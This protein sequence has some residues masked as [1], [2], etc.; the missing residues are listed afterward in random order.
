MSYGGHY[1]GG[2]NGR[3]IH[4]NGRDRDR[5]SSRLDRN[6]RNERNDRNDRNDRSYNSRYGNSQ[7]RYGQ[8]SSSYGEQA[9]GSG[10]RRQE[11]R[12]FYGY[13]NNNN[14]NSPNTNNSYNRADTSDR[15][16]GTSG[17]AVNAR[18]RDRNSQ[19]D[20][21]QG[22]K[23]RPHLGKPKG[24]G[25]AQNTDPIS[26]RVS[27]SSSRND[28]RAEESTKDLIDDRRLSNRKQDWDASMYQNPRNPQNRP[29]HTSRDQY[30][31][32]SKYHVPVK[33]HS[34]IDFEAGSGS[35]KR[36]SSDTEG[37]ESR[38]ENRD[39]KG[40]QSN[41]TNYTKP[42]NKYTKAPYINSS[43]RPSSTSSKQS[44]TENSPV[45]PALGQT[46]SKISPQQSSQ[47]SS[48]MSSQPQT[49]SARPETLHKP[50]EPPVT[51]SNTEGKQK[52]EPSPQYNVESDRK[53]K[54]L[55]SMF[56]DDE[57]NTPHSDPIKKDSSEKTT[58]TK[59]GKSGDTHMED[60]SVSLSSNGCDT[61][62]LSPVGSTASDDAVVRTLNMIPET[63]SNGN[64]SDEQMDLS[65][66]ETIV[67]DGPISMSK[68]RQFLRKKVRDSLRERAR[69]RNIIS[70]DDDD[71]HSD[72]MTDSNPKDL[73]SK[74]LTDEA[75]FSSDSTRGHGEST[76]SE[77][78]SG[79]SASPKSS[80]SE[81]PTKPKDTSS[82]AESKSDNESTAHHKT[83]SK[84]TYKIKRDSTGRSQLQRACKK[85]D[86]HEV[87]SL[88]EKGASANESD[89]G[90]FTCLHEAALA[91]HT[92]IVEYLI[93]NGA[94]VNKQALEAGDFETPL[95]DAA[96]NKHVGTV[97]ALLKN[98]AD[99][100]L[101]NNEGYSTITKLFHLQEDDEEYEDVIK[102]IN[103]FA[104]PQSNSELSKVTHTPREIIEDPSDGYFSNLV[105]KKSKSLIY[106]Y[107]AQGNKESAAEDFVTHSLSL[108]KMPDVL[109]LAARN[110]HVELVDILLGLNP[111][112]FDINQVNKIGVTALLTTVGRGYYDVVKFLLSKG[113]DPRIKR[114]KDGLNALEIAKHSA[115]YD[116]REVVILE[117]SMNDNQKTK[118]S[119]R[120][121]PTLAGD[122]DNAKVSPTHVEKRRKSSASSERRPSVGLN[123]KDDYNGSKNP[124][125][126]DNHESVGSVLAVTPVK[127]TTSDE[128]LRSRGTSKVNEGHTSE[129]SDNE[130]VNSFTSAKRRM[131]SDESNMN[132]KAKRS[133]EVSSK[134]HDGSRR[135]SSPK[136]RLEESGSESTSRFK[137]EAR[138]TSPVEVS[139]SPD[140]ELS[141]VATSSKAQEEQRIRAAEQAKIWQEKM[142][143]KKK[144]RKE[145][146]LLAEKEKEKRR[147][148]EEEM[149]LHLMKQQEDELRERRRREEIEAKKLAEELEKKKQ[150]MEYQRIFQNYPIG[151][152]EV[153][154]DGTFKKEERLKYT[155]LYVFNFDNENW[156]VDMQ[157]CL[158][159]SLPVHQVHSI[160][161]DNVGP[162]V[163]DAS[164][165]RLWSLF[166][167][168]IGVG[169][170]NV[171]E[172]NGME[173]FRCLQLRYVKL[174]DISEW[175]KQ[176]YSEAY[177]TLWTE[178]RLT[179]VDL[180]SLDPAQ[181]KESKKQSNG[182]WNRAD[183]GFIPPKFRY[184][185]DVLKTIQSANSPLW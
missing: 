58:D 77:I 36:S 73:E 184:R 151:L 54:P 177:E 106:K 3:S 79:R 146:F 107:A 55:Q 170:D 49:D 169:K 74:A 1:G 46:N 185:G 114:A 179:K 5:D 68:S 34:K 119:K 102:V 86:L 63:N 128:N 76:K 142:Q 45:T 112:S 90:G 65:E 150:I 145:M 113:A 156:V 166:F 70:S 43:R 35:S 83:D 11:G 104:P 95:M 85:G 97:K 105:K 80:N 126:P 60:M 8:Q 47:S 140:L 30:K 164:K 111:G 98:G 48:Q 6:D 14:N 29:G 51:P 24:P 109:N 91:G 167:K 134:E 52:P 16:Q 162:H 41:Y 99:P 118:D 121:I 174:D 125:T 181:T 37:Q 75:H 157:V 18:R 64:N 93:E 25:Q 136:E 108:S 32:D 89:F 39:K 101:C 88:I 26:M 94:D 92:E 176:E 133:V 82:A 33:T 154:F 9:S 40:P 110:G 96:E 171:I 87:K 53:R 20:S 143:A 132:K 116:P 124:Q 103:D 21:Y 50:V 144:A 12:D 138:S 71:N 57:Y 4:D 13:R 165:D 159:L 182:T 160:F 56:D 131:S 61:S 81:P 163:D 22:S 168:M 120:G 59:E 15:V 44:S 67:E 173:K 123:F 148:E 127:H 23:Y 69:R 42:E 19:Y 27:P 129:M 78:K 141:P 7:K 28:S 66:A 178:N 175:V 38:G 130:Q 139:R 10:Y 135:N 62:V 137:R 147:K 72:E 155:P 158:I 183:M 122:E 153:V 117:E 31:P 115:Q 17:G 180:S 149:K 152:Q 172:R 161:R 100:H 2:S 84:A